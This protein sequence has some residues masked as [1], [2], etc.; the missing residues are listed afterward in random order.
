MTLSKT[1]TPAAS[2]GIKLGRAYASRPWLRPGILVKITDKGLQGGRLYLKKAAVV[3]VPTPDTC[4]LSVAGGSGTVVTGVAAWQVE[5][6][7]PKEAGAA[8]V[9]LA[10]PHAGEAG[11]LLQRSSAAAAA[12]VRLTDGDEVLRLGF[13]DFAA[14]ASGHGD[15]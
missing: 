1:P 11:V 15:D 5:T 6:S 8:V 9:V 2:P 7:V 12:A 3:D 4:S 10:G 13:D 14:A